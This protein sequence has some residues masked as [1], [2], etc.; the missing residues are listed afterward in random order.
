MLTDPSDL[1]HPHFGRARYWDLRM[2]LDRGQWWATR[3]SAIGPDRNNRCGQ[4]NAEAPAAARCGWAGAAGHGCRAQ[5]L[6]GAAYQT[7]QAGHAAA[8]GHRGVELRAV[9]DVVVVADPR[10]AGDHRLGRL[11]TAVDDDLIRR[12]PCRIKGAGHDRA[13]ER[14]TAALDQ[15]F[16]IAEALQPR[17]RLLVLLAAFAQ[18]RFGELIALR[19]RDIN[20]DTME[21]RVA[22]ATAEMQDGTHIG[23]DP[24]S[25][26]GKRPI[27]GRTPLRRPARRDTSPPGSDTP[28]PEPP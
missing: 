12:N 5:A 11:A 17:Y 21:L 26:A 28:A 23:D 13:D 15:V 24:K 18:L 7:G 6:A 2:V 19:R 20:L 1:G 4:A 14:P 22:R 27:N 10:R 25:E 16:A 3:K 9:D 8:V